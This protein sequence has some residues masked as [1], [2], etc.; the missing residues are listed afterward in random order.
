MQNYGHARFRASVHLLLQ[1]R[2]LPRARKRKM[3]LSRDPMTSLSAL[4][5][6]TTLFVDLIRRLLWRNVDA[7]DFLVRFCTAAFD[8]VV[9]DCCCDDVTR[10]GKRRNV[11]N[12]IKR[13]WKSWE[14]EFCNQ[15]SW[16]VLKMLPT[17]HIAYFEDCLALHEGKEIMCFV[18]LFRSSARDLLQFIESIARVN[19][20]AN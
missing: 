20:A 9:D 5:L 18:N 4:S 15:K 7:D 6:A 11:W 13:G 17:A 1:Y 12:A 16:A 10:S 19:W 14:I 3:A 8:V 2:I